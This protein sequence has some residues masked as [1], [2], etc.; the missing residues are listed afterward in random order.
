MH[1]QEGNSV[2]DVDQLF[3]LD[4]FC[5][6]GF[7]VPILPNYTAHQAYFHLLPVGLLEFLSIALQTNRCHS[8]Y[9]L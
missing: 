8:S 2:Q 5:L 6:L 9:D 1:F 3:P 7:D 4:L